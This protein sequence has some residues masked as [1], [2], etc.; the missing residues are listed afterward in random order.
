[1]ILCLAETGDFAQGEHYVEEALR[2]AAIGERPYE[3]VVVDSSTGLFRL[4]QGDVAAATPLLERA[5]ARC[6]AA[7]I[8]H[9]L[10]IV[11]SYLGGA[12]LQSGR[13]SEAMAL[14]ENGVA[15]ATAMRV[16]VH[17]ALSIVFLGQAYRLDGRTHDAK[18]Q[19]EHAIGLS[20]A[21]KEYGNGAW[22]YHLL[23]ETLAQDTSAA[24]EAA[25]TAFR[26]AL[27]QA[28]TYGMQPL[29]AHCHLGLGTLFQ[30]RNRQ[31]GQAA[32][33]R[34]EFA[35]AGALYRSLDMPFWLSRAETI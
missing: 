14:L 11:S 32:Q 7:G 29:Q 28:E 24:T 34:T 16:M 15:Q 22:A 6:R 31:H 21:H 30:H 5:L 33:A 10:P 13:L 2:I 3:Q 9:M 8:H 12:Y 4:R 25:E 35:A 27:A 18:S 26:Q 1:M 20:Q 19:A 23:G 17:H